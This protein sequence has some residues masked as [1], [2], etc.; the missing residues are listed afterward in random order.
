[1]TQK[2]KIY[3]Q[4]IGGGNYSQVPTVILKGKWLKDAGFKCGKYLEVIIE[5]DKI[6]LTKATPPEKSTTQALEERIKNLNDEQKRNWLS[7]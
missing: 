7:S 3:S 2:L 4:S 6:T 1:M 5:G